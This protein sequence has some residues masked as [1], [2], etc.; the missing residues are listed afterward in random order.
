LF[1]IE[2]LQG[3]FWDFSKLPS[4]V[5]P[6]GASSGSY[7]SGHTGLMVIIAL[8]SWD[9]GAQSFAVM[10]TCFCIYLIQVF[11]VYRSHYSIGIPPLTLD[12]IVAAL[13]ATYT[14]L[15]IRPHESRID[16]IFRKA[17]KPVLTPL[18]NIFEKSNKKSQD[19]I[20]KMLKEE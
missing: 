14:V 2:I 10:V 6:Y 7:F 4:F 11:M 9:L 13:A 12:V 3:F 15:L 19:K 8:E 5:V 1:K 18:K 16:S 20:E 17:L